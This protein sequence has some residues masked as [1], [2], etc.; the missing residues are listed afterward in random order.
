MRP[1]TSSWLPAVEMNVVVLYAVSCANALASNCMR[2]GHGPPHGSS[3]THGGFAGPALAGAPVVARAPRTA[4]T[5]SSFFIRDLLCRGRPLP[6]AGIQ[7]QRYSDL[8]APH[9]L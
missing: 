3:G 9:V 4:A 5:P 1:T 8:M 2:I 6:R 7:G